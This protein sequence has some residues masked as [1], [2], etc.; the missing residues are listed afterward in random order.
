VIKLEKGDMATSLED[1]PDRPDDRRAGI[2][3]RAPASIA[4]GWHDLGFDGPKRAASRAR[5]VRSG[6][7]APAV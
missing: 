7:S 4:E 2:E 1:Q 5:R 3:I 6:G